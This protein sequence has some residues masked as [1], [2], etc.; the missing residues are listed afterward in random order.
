MIIGMHNE[1]KQKLVWENVWKN[2]LVVLVTAGAAPLIQT[3][4]RILT[5]ESLGNF[6]LVVSMLLVTV[7]FANFAFTY[8]DS[9]LQSGSVRLLSHV[10]T[11]LFL[12]LIA[13]LLVAMT[14]GIGIVYPSLFSFF[15]IFSVLLYIAVALY[16]FWDLLRTK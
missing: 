13:L 4:V 10:A 11:F 9:N 3:S 2:L 15:S 8:K 14:I 1:I 12:L 7:C 16:D 6:L 5:P